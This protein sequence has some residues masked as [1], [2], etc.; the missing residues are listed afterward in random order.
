[1]IEQGAAILDI[2]GQSTRPGSTLVTA[3]QEID[4]VIP[5]IELI[6]KAFPE[7]IISV[8]TF[9]AAVARAAVLQG[10]HMINDV[11]AGGM[12]TSLLDEVAAL[13]VPYVLMHMPGTPQTMLGSSYTNLTLDLFDFFSFKIKELIQKGIK[14]IIIDVGFGFGKNAE[15][16][17]ELLRNLSFFKSLCLPIMVGLSRKATIYKT[18]NITPEEALNGSSVLHT[19]ALLNG[20]GIL[21]VHDVKEA[22]EAIK[23]YCAYENKKEQFE[24]APL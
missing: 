5:A 18:L 22:M 19:I 6:H 13:Q 4:R 12:D 9:Y 21:R 17:F 8:D 10:A 7:Q 11:S 2:G 15:Q 16:N 20:A 24:T 1:M 23:L 14:D 3:E